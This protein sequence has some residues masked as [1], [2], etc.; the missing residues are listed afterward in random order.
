MLDQILGSDPRHDAVSVVDAW[1]PHAAE[2]PVDRAFAAWYHV[3]Y[4]PRSMWDMAATEESL[5]P[6]A[7][8]LVRRRATTARALRRLFSGAAHGASRMAC[9]NGAMASA[10]LPPSSRAWPFSS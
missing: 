3:L 5:E 7:G 2:D 4:V 1:E 9:C 10:A 8:I 6:R